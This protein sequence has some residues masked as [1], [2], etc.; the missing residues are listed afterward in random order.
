MESIQ[1]VEFFLSSLDDSTESGVE[2]CWAKRKET[3]TVS[4]EI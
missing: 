2:I 4:M 1:A 3:S